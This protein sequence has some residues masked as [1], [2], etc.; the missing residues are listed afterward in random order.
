MSS[1]LLLLADE[2]FF[3]AARAWSFYNFAPVN[4][5]RCSRR[6]EP[7]FVAQLLGVSQWHA[8]DVSSS[9]DARVGRIFLEHL[10]FSAGTL[11][12][13]QPGLA[14]TGR[15]EA[16]LLYDL[17]SVDGG[18]KLLQNQTKPKQKLAQELSP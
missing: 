13:S 11:S 16:R 8:E 15:V 3:H 5:V 9:F 6:S 17:Y 4:I 7:A 18:V 1:V 10:G 12:P 14:L 2:L